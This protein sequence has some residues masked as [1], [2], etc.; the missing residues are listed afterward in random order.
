MKEFKRYIVWNE[1]KI[2]TLSIQ[3]VNLRLLTRLMKP[4]K[5]SH[6]H[7]FADFY[8]IEVADF[9]EIDTSY[10]KIPFATMDNYPV[11]VLISN[12]LKDYVF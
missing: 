5:L 10:I 6:Q 1:E 9:D 4:H 7:I 3:G 12:F 2:S 8:E 11:P